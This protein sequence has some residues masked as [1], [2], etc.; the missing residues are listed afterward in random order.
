MA[1]L[2]V[3]DDDADVLDA[4]CIMLRT[5]GYAVEKAGGGLAALEIIERKRIDR[6]P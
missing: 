4:V 6:S 2:L 1:S 5:A 3:V